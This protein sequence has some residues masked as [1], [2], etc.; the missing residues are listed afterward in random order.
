MVT[1][2]VRWRPDGTRRHWVSRRA[3]SYPRK[4][5]FLS[6]VL[7]N[8]NNFAGLAAALARVC[9]V[10]E[11]QCGPRGPGPPERPGGPCETSVLRGFKGPVKGP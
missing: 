7:L 5:V 11:L 6:G 9:A 3:E 4:W 10:V 1:V 2:T 8:S